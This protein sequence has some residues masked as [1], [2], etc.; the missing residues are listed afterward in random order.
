MA[1]ETGCFKQRDDWPRR[2]VY[3]L[4]MR[5]LV[6]QTRQNVDQWLHC[7]DFADKVGVHVLMG[8]NTPPIGTSTQSAML[9]S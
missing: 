3:C 9:Y 5:T 1:L 2:L 8:E 6:E 7:L 4:P